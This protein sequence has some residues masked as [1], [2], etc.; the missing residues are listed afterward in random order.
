MNAWICECHCS[1]SYVEACL[2]C[3]I[4]CLS[5]VPEVFVD[6]EYTQQGALIPPAKSKHIEPSESAARAISPFI[7]GSSESTSREN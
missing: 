2:K 6:I 1:C 3:P 5:S 7:D 4:C